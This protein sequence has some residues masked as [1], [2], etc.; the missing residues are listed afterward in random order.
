MQSLNALTS[1]SKLRI[2]F[3]KDESYQA[4]LPRSVDAEVLERRM[5][6]ASLED[7]TQGKLWAYLDPQRRLSKREKDKLDL[8]Q[9]AEAYPA[10]K[11][12]YP[13]E[14]VTLINGG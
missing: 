7:V 13:E 5:K 9:L 8:I 4:F 12:M 3:T 14:L 6:V 10:L 1:G 11:S 2:Q